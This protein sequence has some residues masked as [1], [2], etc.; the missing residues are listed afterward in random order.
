MAAAALLALGC[1]MAPSLAVQATHG[2]NG[3]YGYKRHMERMIWIQA[4]YVTS[5]TWYSYKRPGGMQVG[6]DP[7]RDPR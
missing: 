4:A 5:G 1:V 6:D 3:N 2:T 7:R